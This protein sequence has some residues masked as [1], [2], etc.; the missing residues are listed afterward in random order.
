[1]DIFALIAAFG[2]GLFGGAIGALP[3]F[4]FTGFVALAG[5]LVALAG[6]T[7][8]L[9][10]GAIAF[11]SFFGPHIGFASGVAAAAFAANK[12]KLAGISAGTNILYSPFGLNDPATLIVGGVFGVVGFLINYLYSAVL[13]LPTDTIAMTVATSGILVRF[14]FGKSGLFGK[15]DASGGAKREWAPSGAGF[16]KMVLLGLGMGCIV[17]GIGS[18]LMNAPG[19]NVAAVVSIFPVVCFG[20]SASTLIFAQTGYAVPATHHITLPAALATVLSGGNIAVGICV[21]IICSLLGDIVVK[22]FNSHCDTH[23][24]MPAIVIFLSTFAI[25]GIWG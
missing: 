18:S 22:V 7:T 11:G 19:V 15:F 21:G 10:V 2:G 12:R 6:S 5:G 24:D 9:G 13:A 3:A 4:I 17:G 16:G 1:M 25:L 14:I 20:I 8:E 23:I